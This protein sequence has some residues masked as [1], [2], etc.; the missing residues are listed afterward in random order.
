MHMYALSLS[1]THTHNWSCFPF[2]SKNGKYSHF[3]PIQKICI[4]V[5]KCGNFA[6]YSHFGAFVMEL[7]YFSILNWLSTDVL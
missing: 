5:V 4:N 7:Q 6:S 1:H 3:D 2:K